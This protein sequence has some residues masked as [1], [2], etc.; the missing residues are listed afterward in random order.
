[1][2]RVSAHGLLSKS[3][4]DTA[5][6]A[7]LVFAGALAEQL[8]YEHPALGLGLFT[9]A[10][11]DA[12]SDPAFFSLAVEK[13]DGENQLHCDFSRLFIFAKE[14]TEQ[15][16]YLYAGG[17]LQTPIAHGAGSLLLTWNETGQETAP[18]TGNSTRFA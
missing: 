10:L 6:N 5:I 8:A 4:N 2:L 7:F 13:T 12:M 1:M 18:S 3:L 9:F 14:R 16:A 11:H 15:L 17:R